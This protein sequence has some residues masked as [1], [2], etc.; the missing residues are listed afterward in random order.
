MESL[1]EAKRFA[2]RRF[3]FGSLFLRRAHI[4]TIQNT[5]YSLCRLVTSSPSL[6]SASSH[7]NQC[8]KTLWWRMLAPPAAAARVRFFPHS[9]DVI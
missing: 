9:T 5:L 2:K 8:R 3:F 1:G 4:I 6:Q 7:S